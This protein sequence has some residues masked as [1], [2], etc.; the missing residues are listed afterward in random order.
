MNGQVVDMQINVTKDTASVGIVRLVQVL[1]SASLKR[2]VGTAAT[3]FTKGRLEAQPSNKQGWPS[4]GFYQKCSDGTAYTVVPSGVQ[5]L[6]DNAAAPGALKHAY[7]RGQAGKVYIFA[8]GK[9]LTVPARAEFYGH[10]AGE[11]DN[12]KFVQFKSGAK[13]LVIGDGGTSRFSGR[14]AEKRRGTGAKS[15]SVVA[16]W[17]TNSVEQDAR[18]TVIPSK[19][20]YLMIIGEALADGVRQLTGG[21]N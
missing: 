16:Y 11:F 18:P 1:A 17:L 4:Q 12:L 9:L 7:N 10:R 3:E 2:L 14:G 6:S 15:A 21:N 5:I 13:A 20:E 8:N 19:A